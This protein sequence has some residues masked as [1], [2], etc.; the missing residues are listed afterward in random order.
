MRVRRAVLSDSSVIASLNGAVQKLH[1]D[2]YPRQFK[3]PDAAAV[4]PHFTEQL[5]R[6]T[7]VAFVVEAANHAPVGYVL[8]ETLRRSEDGF[9]AA[10]VALY[11]H[12]IAVL[13]TQRGAGHGRAL[14]QAVEQEAKRQGIGEVRLD[15]WEFNENARRFF[16]SLGYQP[17]NVRARKQL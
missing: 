13:P 3:A 4:E 15:Y 17:F 1:H 7:V 5:R 6:D 9:L 16:A 12:H 11:V 8:A 2:A 10:T 14:M